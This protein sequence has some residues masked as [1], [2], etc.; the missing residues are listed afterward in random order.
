MPNFIKIPSGGGTPKVEVLKFINFNAF[1][2]NQQKITLEKDYRFVIVSITKATLTGHNGSGTYAFIHSINP[3]RTLIENKESKTSGYGRD[4][5]S[6]LK[7]YEDCKQGDV[8]EAGAA[9]GTCI[10]VTIFG[11]I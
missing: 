7:I 1:K 9:D 11:V 3:N 2:G 5:Q 10:N 4:A 8:I 6:M